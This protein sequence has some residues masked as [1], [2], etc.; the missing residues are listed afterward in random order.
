MGKLSDAIRKNLENRISP[1]SETLRETREWIEKLETEGFNV[2]DL[3]KQQQRAE[4]TL[5]RVMAL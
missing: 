1:Q 5:E 2:S 3:K 4:N